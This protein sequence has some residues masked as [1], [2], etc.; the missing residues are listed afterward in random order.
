MK[1][2]SCF[3]FVCKVFV[4]WDQGKTLK[5][6]YDE[7]V[8]C[9]GLLDVG[10]FVNYQEWTN[11][12]IN[13]II[14]TL[15]KDILGFFSCKLSMIYLFSQ[16]SKSKCFNNVRTTLVIFVLI[17]LCFVGVYLV[18]LYR[19]HSFTLLVQIKMNGILGQHKY[20]YPYLNVN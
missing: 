8:V 19:M 16:R 2:G 7:F 3:P 5:C 13:C 6:C 9:A 17:Y 10:K 1:N 18:H 11:D 20:M 4:T 15:I 12:V 14:F